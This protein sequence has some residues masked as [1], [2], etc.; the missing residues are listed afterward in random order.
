MTFPPMPL[1][2]LIRALEREGIHQTDIGDALYAAD[3]D[4]GGVAPHLDDDQRGRIRQLGLE[5]N[6]ELRRVVPGGAV[7]RETFL[8]LPMLEKDVSRWLA[9][10]ADCASLSVAIHQVLPDR[11]ERP[12]VVL[13][14]DHLLKRT[15]EAV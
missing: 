4:W 1:H 11:A 7:Q 3:P 8:V 2:D 6:V 9:H 13:A 10:S 12:R 15:T 14:E 5:R